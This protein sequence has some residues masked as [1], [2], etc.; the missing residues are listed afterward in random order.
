MTTELRYLHAFRAAAAAP[1][2]EARAALLAEIEVAASSPSAQPAA[3]TP[4]A[5]APAARS[6]PAVPA[7]GR[8][9]RRRSLLAGLGG[10]AAAGA[11]AV[12]IALGTGVG[13]GDVRPQPASAV[14]ALRAA[15]GAASAQPYVPL[16]PGRYWYV[17]TS[18]FGDMTGSDTARRTMSVTL[19]VTTERWTAPGRW[20]RSRT[21]IGTAARFPTERDRRLWIAAG[22]PWAGTVHDDRGAPSPYDRDER[23]FASDRLGTAR[24]E[25]LPEEVERLAE[26]VRQIADAGA[27]AYG[28]AG[29]AGREQVW[30]TAVR[31]L[32]QGDA[33]LPPRTRAA[34]FEVLAQIPGVTSRGTV[35]DARG[36][37]GTAIALTLFGSLR[38]EL[39]VDERTGTLLET[40]SS[41][42]DG[43]F[44]GRTTFL[45][46]GVVDSVRARP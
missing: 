29:S 9:R 27:A 19:P 12:A 10:L 16:T 37:S 34:L 38:E 30:G 24:P 33:P 26:R 2:E 22:R 31:L 25:D 36:R 46:S 45:A 14:E 3:A 18:G 42:R 1:D 4:S 20:S 43:S 40:R 28:G 11:A 15:A 6:A 35:R 5:P 23:P 17:K 41:G 32:A 7:G 44:R 13:G 8:A 21:A 39:V